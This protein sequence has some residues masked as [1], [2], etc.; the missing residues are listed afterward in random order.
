MDA[1]S[2]SAGAAPCRRCAATDDAADLPRLQAGGFGATVEA[3][4]LED[5]PGVRGQARLWL[6]SLL[7]SRQAVEAIWA[8]L[9][10]GKTAL[11]STRGIGPARPCALAPEGPRGWPSPIVKLRESTLA[12]GLIHPRSAHYAH[13]RADFL[14]IPRLDP[15]GTESVSDPLVATQARAALA[16]QHF[17]FLNRRVDTPLHPAWAA[18]L[19]TRAVDRGEAVELDSYGLAAYR[20]MPD[21]AALTA[22]VQDGVRSGEL[23]VPP[24]DGGD[25]GV[26]VPRERPIHRNAA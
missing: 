5:D 11:L 25:R 6:V 1:T 3:Y 21:V 8:A 18:W 26:I 7:A 22:A 14:L 12:H 23:P 17:R 4:A 24:V 20:C 19:W 10:T 13:D 15:R 16:A 2:Q 9:V